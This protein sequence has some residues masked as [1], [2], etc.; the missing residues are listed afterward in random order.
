MMDGIKYTT[1]TLIIRKFYYVNNT[2]IKVI[3]NILI[4]KKVV[5]TTLIEV[6]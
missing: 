1:Q 5:L 4:F 3:I 6:K 2:S